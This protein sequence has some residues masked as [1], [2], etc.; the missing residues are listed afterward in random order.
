MSTFAEVVRA[1]AHDERVGL[2]FEERSWTWAQV[3]AEGARR[4]AWLRRTGVRHVGLLLENVPDH[5]FWIVAAALEGAV[6]VGLN[7]TR[8]GVGLARD[9][10]HTDCEVVVTETRSAG[11]LDGID[12]GASVL[13]VDS[14]LDRLPDH[15]ALPSVSPE[16]DRTLLLL[17][18]SG[19]TGAPKAVIC[20]QGRLGALAESLAMRTELTRDS[21][22]YLCMPLFHG[23]SAMM[24]LAPAMHV[25]STVC[26]ARKFSASGFARDVHRYGVT[27]VNYVGR[28]LSYVLAQP[29]G[30]AD[31]RSTL[32]LAVGTEAS[33]ADAERFAERFGCRVSEGYG[34]SEGVLRINRTPDSPPDS[35]GLPVDGIDVRVLRED[36]GTECPRAVFDERGRL[37]NAD[38]AVGQIVAIGGARSFEGYYNNPEAEAERVRGEDFWTGDLAYRDADGFFHF[39]GR[40]A[41]RLRVDGENF[42]AASVERILQRWEP[43]EA[44][45]VYPVPDPRTGDQVMCAL[46]LRGEFDPT[47]FADFLAAQPDLGTK[48]LPRFVRVTGEIPLT[49]SNKTAKTP[50]RHEAWRTDDPVHFR[51]TAQLR[52]HRFGAEDLRRWESAF[53]IDARAALLPP[54]PGSPRR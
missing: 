2:R 42:A 51:P 6:V 23:N 40:T 53:A 50:L 7:P 16:P 33:P 54:E 47:A 49:A 52:Y 32:R 36:T 34:M 1:R 46:Q 41:D 22:S 38:Q 30:P 27:F 21:V 13:D 4:A 24:N 9:I 43:V 5:V 19:S 12:H 3:V 44:V 25:G 31:R 26:L 14:D 17:F 11:L 37:V 18:S 35:L 10:R 20:S 8:R 48:W 39:A 45:A 29:E 28:A 15:A